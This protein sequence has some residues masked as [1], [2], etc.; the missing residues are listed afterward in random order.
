M[1]VNYVNWWPVPPYFTVIESAVITSPY[2]VPD[3]DIAVTDVTVR[4]ILNCADPTYRNLVNVTVLNE[5]DYTETFD[6][7]VYVENTT[8]EIAIGTQ[9]VI[10]LASSTSTTLNFPWNTDS[11]WTLSAFCGN[12]TVRAYAWPVVGET[13]LLDNNYIDGEVILKKIGDLGGLV[14]PQFLKFD[15]ACDGKDLSL[16]LS[17]FKGTPPPNL[18]LLGDLGGGLP[19]AFFNYDGLCNGKDLSLFLQCFKG[20]GP[21]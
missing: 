1:L 7:T 11:T 17:C 5:G 21:C 9:T 2:E 16:F 10:D 15:G 14:P 20:L 4:E 3:H 12:Y 19:P 6:V 18:V 8:V 13:D